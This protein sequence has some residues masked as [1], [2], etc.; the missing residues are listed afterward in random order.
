VQ[1]APENADVTRIV[2]PAN[3]V[4]DVVIMQSAVRDDMPETA[5]LLSGSPVY[6]VYLRVGDQREWLLEYCI[7]SAA[8]PQNMY[9]IDVSDPGEIS[10]PYPMTTVVP[11]SV[12]GQRSTRYTVL[13]GFITAAGRL[14]NVTTA[15][16]PAQALARQLL[17]ALPE[18]QFRPVLQNRKPIEVEI[19][20]LIP[21]RS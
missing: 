19:L 10:P 4:F 18:W 3:A 1:P 16:G 15:A 7:P 21:P 5:G 8:R 17:P 6:T 14:R 11:N 9:Q 2:H 20:L 13:H 12:W